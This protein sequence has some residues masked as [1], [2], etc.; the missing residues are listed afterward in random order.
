M[1]RNNRLLIVD[2][3][4]SIIKCVT[5][6]LRQ[7]EYEIFT[8]TSGEAGLNIIEKYNI[9]VVLSDFKMPGMSGI[10]FLK[11]VKELRSNIARILFTAYATI[12]NAINAIN[13]VQIFKYL[14]KPWS[15]NELNQTIKQAF[16]YH[17]LLADNQQMQRE[18]EE[19][20]I[21]L[22][23]INNNLENLVS[24]RTALLEDSIREGVMML[25]M[26]A[27]AKDDDTGEHLNRISS[28]T[29]EICLAY[30]LTPEQSDKIG[31]FSIMHDI[32]KIHIPDIILQK[33]GSLEPGEWDI[34]RTHCVAGEK[35][36]GEKPFYR[37]AR[38]IARSHHER[39]D[40]N[41]YP[42]GLTKIN[43]PLSAR[44]VS[45]AD[46]FDALTSKRKYKEAWTM[47]AALE[48][49]KNLSSKA[50]DPDI[51]SVFLEVMSKKGKNRN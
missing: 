16:N 46:V 33:T 30:G 26:A 3:E 29:R 14:T 47:E 21:L 5:R 27:E 28:L 43:I 10:E 48:E 49:M 31:F 32:G 37:L 51:M 22:Q 23:N 8:A 4:Q 6:Q 12:E 50:F 7:D 38:E 25:A 2:D 34:M 45:I 20:N 19:K 39:W 24:T 9:G 15:Q 17:N 11:K 35:I 44:I 18:I 13:D 41:G 42:D 1:M 40:G 36:L